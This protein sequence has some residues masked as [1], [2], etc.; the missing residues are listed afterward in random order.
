MSNQE[1]V[2]E[3][4]AHLRNGDMQSAF[5]LLHEDFVLHQADSL[6]YGGDY[7]GHDGI[8]QFFG[9]L[10]ETWGDFGSYNV[11]YIDSGD[12]VVAISRMKGT[13]KGTNTTLDIPMVQ[14]YKIKD[15]KL[16]ETYPFYWDTAAIA[17]A[18]KRRNQEG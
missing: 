7:V 6:P 4:Y 3:F 11:E 2:E 1:I 17:E 9:L 14:V 12:R 13:I 18:V 5:S 10:G 16:L 8:R 15:G